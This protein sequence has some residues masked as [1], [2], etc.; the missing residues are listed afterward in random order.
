MKIS[1]V[2]SILF[3]GVLL[4]SCTSKVAPTSFVPI[5]SSSTSEQ[6]SWDTTFPAEQIRID[7][8]TWDITDTVPAFSGIAEGYKYL[9]DYKQLV[10]KV[11]EGYEASTVSIYSFDFLNAS[12]TENGV[13]CFATMHYLSPSKKLDIS[14]WHDSTISN[15]GIVYVD[16]ANCIPDPTVFPLEELN[17][18]L[19]TYGFN[20][21]VTAALPNPQGETF[22]HYT[23]KIE[24]KHYFNIG[25]LGNVW[26]LW[27]D[28]L[29]P[30]LTYAGY[31]LNPDYTDPDEPYS[32]TY[33]NE[34]GHQV[35]FEYEQYY[36][37]SRVSFFE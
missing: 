31:E 23:D 11:A 27:Q 13:D 20:F 3:A 17:T 30:T 12:Y 21:T 19:V 18:F 35:S 26:T 24:N 25:M 16:F 37:M 32:Y 2:L 22:I 4:A 9:P 29:V 34:A 28:A 6:E 36:K 15:P 10:I 1:K 33:E 5:P 7:L 8:A 14:I